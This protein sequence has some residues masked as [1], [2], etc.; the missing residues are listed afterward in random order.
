MT[1]DQAAADRIER[2]VEKMVDRLDSRYMAGFIEEAAY[3]ARMRE[4]DA[5]A[6]A[7][8]R[9]RFPMPIKPAI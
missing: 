8:Y 2:Q 4:I 1:K 3:H 7:Q 9:P 5:W 6:E